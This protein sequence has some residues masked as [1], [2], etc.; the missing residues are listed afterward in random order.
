MPNDIPDYLGPGTALQAVADPLTFLNVIDHRRYL[1][2]ATDDNEWAEG[3]YGRVLVHDNCENSVLRWTQVSGTISSDTTTYLKGTRSIKL[4]TPAGAGSQ[5]I[6]RQFTQLAADQGTSTFPLVVFECYFKDFDANLRDIQ[7]FA[8][9]DDTVS[10][11]VG[12]VRFQFRQAGSNVMQIQ[13]LDSTGTFVSDGTYTLRAG[14]GNVGDAYHH[15]MVCWDYLQGS[16]GYLR[17]HILKIDDMTIK[18]A[19][20]PN[21]QSVATGGFRE[22]AFDI[23]ASDDNAG[24]ST[25]NVDEIWA[26]DLSNAFQL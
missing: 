22:S 21:A 8:R 17:Y 6:M 4:V 26:G 19:S 12:A 23:I 16:S 14:G 10:K 24:T 15:L 25:L 11:F 7:M 2:T 20:P 1:L 13:H 5:A 3:Q 18:P 9:L